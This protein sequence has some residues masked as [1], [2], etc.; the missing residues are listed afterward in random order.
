MLANITNSKSIDTRML[1]N[2]GVLRC[3]LSTLVKLFGKPTFDASVG[4]MFD[5]PESRAWHLKLQD[6]TVVRIADRKAFGDTT[7]NNTND[8]W[9]VQAFNEKVF[10]I[11]ERLVKDLDSLNNPNSTFAVKL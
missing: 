7:I 1:H 3:P 2:V 4:D 10:H 6:G 8:V 5:A 11:V 9:Y